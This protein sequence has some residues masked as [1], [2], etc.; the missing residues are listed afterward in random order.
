MIS[1]YKLKNK[2]T[3]KR[4]NPDKILDNLMITLHDR[5]EKE[6]EKGNFKLVNHL[7]VLM[8]TIEKDIEWGILDPDSKKNILKYL[9]E[10]KSVVESVIVDLISLE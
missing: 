10:K 2:K 6:S 8:T 1:K 3:I 7:A 5:A 9:R 4:S